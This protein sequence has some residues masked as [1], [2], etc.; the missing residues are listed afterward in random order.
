MF[1]ER[2]EVEE[3][4]KGRGQKKKPPRGDPG[5]PEELSSPKTRGLKTQRLLPRI[6]IPVW[7]PI[8]TAP[9]WIIPNS[10]SAGSAGSKGEEN[11]M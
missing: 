8:T 6:P 5:G 2:P 7:N 11:W 9:L 3:R 10:G 4:R 1:L